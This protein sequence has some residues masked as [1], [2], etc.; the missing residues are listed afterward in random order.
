[1]NSMHV[2]EKGN[3]LIKELEELVYDLVAEHNP[4]APATTE[5]FS[6]KIGL[7][8]SEGIEITR[9]ILK[10]LKSYGKIENLHGNPDAWKIKS[11]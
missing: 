4:A 3:S 8:S 9:N 7:M 10:R 5:N 1:M 2:L 11:I 6:S